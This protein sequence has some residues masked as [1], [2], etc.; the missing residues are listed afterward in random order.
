M[1]AAFSA[2]SSFYTATKIED[3]GKPSL[4]AIAT[5]AQAQPGD[6][7]EPTIQPTSASRAKRCIICMLSS[8]DCF[9]VGRS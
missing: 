8:K 3:R 1:L 2:S 7:G 5:D 4:L 9:S 6:N